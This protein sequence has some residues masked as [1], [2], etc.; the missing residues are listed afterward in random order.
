MSVYSQWK[1]LSALVV[2]AVVHGSEAVERMQRGLVATPFQVLEQIP[3]LVGPMKVV[4]TVH[5]L[6]LTTTHGT[7]RLTAKVVGTALAAGLD[8][9]ENQPPGGPAGKA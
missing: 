7:I 4:R 2:D 6:A 5:D 3:P 9:A 1:G 8:L